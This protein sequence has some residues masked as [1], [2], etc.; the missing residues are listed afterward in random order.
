MYRNLINSVENPVKE[1]GQYCTDWVP[2]QHKPVVPD[3]ICSFGKARLHFHP[4]CC[5]DGFG[6]KFFIPEQ[7]IS[8]DSISPQ[9]SSTG[10]STSSIASK[11]KFLF[12]EFWKERWSE[13]CVS[14][15]LQPWRT[16]WDRFSCVISSNTR[17]C[18]L[19][20]IIFFPYFCCLYWNKIKSFNPLRIQWFHMLWPTLIYTFVN[21]INIFPLYDSV[22]LIFSS[23]LAV[24]V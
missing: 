18:D 23:H 10:S 20:G 13:L 5:L 11:C 17:G 19:R 21:A 3:G 4:V 16:V 14:A 7:I 6:E 22:G 1:W 9:S 15:P 2:H 8:G 12:E 24:P